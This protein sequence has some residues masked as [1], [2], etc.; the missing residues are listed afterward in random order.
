MDFI[1]R[2]GIPGKTIGIFSFNLCMMY[3]GIFN[4][5][6]SMFTCIRHVR[7]EV[8]GRKVTAAVLKTTLTWTLQAWSWSA[9]AFTIA[10][11]RVKHGNGI[12]SKHFSN[13]VAIVLVAT[14][15]TCSPC[16]SKSSRHAFGP[17]AFNCA[18]CMEGLEC[19]ALSQLAAS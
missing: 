8:P 4:F 10:V 12:L 1:K 13:L 9:D 2:I 19:P 15:R 3:L 16:C 7:D 14:L 18:K 6:R 17:G 11:S 5:R